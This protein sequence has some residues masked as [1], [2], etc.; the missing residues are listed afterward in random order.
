[1]PE[2][3]K[4]NPNDSNDNLIED[5]SVSSV[6]FPSEESKQNDSVN[7]IQAPQIQIIRGDR[8]SQ[9]F[10]WRLEL[11]NVPAA[12]AELNVQEE[13]IQE[14]IADR[15][16][17]ENDEQD[18]SDLISCLSDGS[19][20]DVPEEGPVRFAEQSDRDPIEAKIQMD[21]SRG[22]FKRR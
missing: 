8:Q 5:S 15:P 16:A 18:D 20:E 17:A 1:M 13:L 7:N 10:H 14:E 11:E 21:L 3:E 4:F 19:I 22:L 12:Q 9:I 6:S 2:E